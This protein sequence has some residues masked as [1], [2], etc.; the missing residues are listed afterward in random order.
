MDALLVIGVGGPEGK[1]LV[2][3]HVY[4]LVGA[5]EELMR[6]GGVAVLGLR[7]YSR[8]AG[9]LVMINTSMELLPQSHQTLSSAWGWH[10]QTHLTSPDSNSTPEVG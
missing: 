1:G 10:A 9:F 7:G 8:S 2:G 4:I 3:S 5:P 6:A